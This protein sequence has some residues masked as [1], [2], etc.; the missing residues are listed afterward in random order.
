MRAVVVLLSLVLTG[1]AAHRHA[2]LNY[3]VM[4]ACL[5]GPVQLLDCDQATPPHCKKIIVRYQKACEQIDLK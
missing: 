4:P 2:P 5:T 1:C 3:A